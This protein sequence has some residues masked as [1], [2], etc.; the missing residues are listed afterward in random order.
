VETERWQRIESIYHAA[1]ER[2]Q[3]RRAEFVEQACDGDALLQQEVISLLAETDGAESFL[4]APALQM[5]ARVLA[6]A[7]N[8]S[9]ENASTSHPPFIGRYRVI[10]LLGEGGMGT[11]YEA[12]QDQPRR[13]VALKIIRPGLTNPAG[14]R[15]FKHE[16][17]AL[18]RLQHPG[19]AQVYEANTADTGFGPQPYFAMELIRG[20][21]LDK[22]AE[23]HSLNTRQKLMLMAKICAAVQ[24]AH[25]RG[26]IHR[27][28]KPGNILVDETGQPKILDFGVARVTE[29]EGQP[30]LQT[31][32]GQI[33]GTLAYMSPEQ[34]LGDPLDVDTRSD[35]YSL[36]VVLYELL[37]GR[38]P[39]NVRGRQ[40][41]EAVQTIR[42][43]DPAALS[44][45]S[46]NYR[47]DVETIVGKALEK[48]KT[49]RYASATALAA[50]IDRYLSDEPILARPPSASYQLQKFARRHRTLVGSV[51]A[52]FVVLVAGIA[53]STALAIR[54]SRAK[55]DAIGARDRAVQ[56]EEQTRMQRD[57]AAA[58]EQTATRQRDLAVIAQQEAV[59]EQNRALLEKQRADDQA[60]T[61]KAESNFLENDLLAQAGAKAQTRAGV[62]PD[63]DLKVRTALDRAAA[64]IEGKFD[65]QPLVEASIRLTIGKAYSDLGVY[66]EAQRQIERAI[67]LRRRNLGEENPDTLMSVRSLAALYAAQGRLP[68]AEDSYNHVLE[69]QQRL[70]GIEHRDTLE[71]T[72][73]LAMMYDDKGQT[74]RAESLLNE[75]LASQRRVLG[76]ED[77]ETLATASSL[78]EVYMERNQDAKAEPL[79]TQTLK[80]QQRVLGEDHPDTLMSLAD[81]ATIY[82]SQGKY[83]QA[84]PLLTKVL[85]VQR[86]ELG[87]EHRQTLS[88]MNGLAILYL[89]EG[90]FAQAEPLFVR[91]LE[92]ERRI[93]GEEHRDTLNTMQNLAALYLKE[94]KHKEAEP[95]LDKTLE[96]QRRLLGAE[97]RET[98]ASM[99][100]LASLYLSEGK[101]SQAEPLYTQ[102]LTIRRRALGDEDRQT[103]SSMNNLSELYRMMGRYAE[104]EPLGTKVLETRRRVLGAENASTLVSM[105]GLGT[106]YRA[107]GRYAEAEPLLTKALE[108]RRRILGEEHPS[109][110]NS[111][112]D[113]AALRKSEGKYVE[114]DALFATALGARRRVL[115]PA[116]PD[117]LDDM[118]SLAEVRLEEKKHA[119]AEPLLRE[120]LAGY[121]KTTPGSWT[122]YRC[123][124]LL[125]ASLA[126]QGKFVEAESLLVDGYRGMTSQTEAIPFEYRSGTEQAGLR[127]V[128]LYEGWGK[129]D[130]AG[131]WREKLPAK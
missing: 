54:A 26:L 89:S 110:L 55:Q 44:S 47:G 93:L 73:Q 20:V 7:S 12:E 122:Q 103:L 10:R 53:V 100:N 68:Q 65:R 32:V 29:G 21:S 104:A 114:A 118:V 23:A 28:L 95:L 70:L 36:G 37:S 46:R 125:G 116:H 109:T 120:A 62:K 16:S 8:G 30:T 75:A 117:T 79:L 57:R 33:V 40:I 66:P 51:A 74:E 38:P 94:G 115:G 111:V 48:D 15:R 97:N 60:A 107:E 128:Q 50:D 56:A 105:D 92:V 81:L 72:Y 63:P 11:V 76:E 45:I 101:Y 49:R 83:A 102:V 41:H 59:R 25:E 85:E 9:G 31:E 24:H 22:Y 52:V 58:A 82:S 88:G 34:V 35:V 42:E 129:P 4:E 127:I 106:L 14:L 3:G 112:H 113:L 90:K 91:A 67:E 77:V 126:G 27:D 13:I 130:K 84:E 71:T 2:E 86:H 108:A 87:E 43:E 131:A 123:Q 1:L 121:E 124:S 119:D 39:Y 19:I 6:S 98:L 61:A 78:C 17:Q 64:H 69:A 96:I 99:N 18:G 80:T 5:A